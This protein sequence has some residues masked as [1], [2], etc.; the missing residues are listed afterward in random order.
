METKSMNAQVELPFRFCIRRRF[1]VS[2]FDAV[3]IL[4]RL[5]SRNTPVVFLL[6][7]RIAVFVV[8]AFRSITF[9][10]RFIP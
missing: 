6:F 8:F 10:F 5:H 3:S 4:L 1:A 2:A 7:R 9:A